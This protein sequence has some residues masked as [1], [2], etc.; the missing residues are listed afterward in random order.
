[1]PRKNRDIPTRPAGTVVEVSTRILHA[2][3]LLTPTDELVDLAIGALGRALEVSPLQLCGISMLSNHYHALAVVE[4]QQQLSRFFGHTV[5]HAF[6]KSLGKGPDADPQL[7]WL[8][9]RTATAVGADSRGL[10]FRGLGS[11]GLCGSHESAVFD[12]HEDRR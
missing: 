8:V 5:L 7:R 3:Y 4:D 12:S 10:G 1:M 2:A 6:A 11:R 9:R